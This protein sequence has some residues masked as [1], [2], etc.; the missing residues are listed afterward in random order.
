MAE[1]KK[2]AKSDGKSGL[3]G[4]RERYKKLQEKY[5]LPAF[6]DMNREFYIEK[7]AEIETDI[8]T[9]EIRRFVADKIYNYLR[10]LETILNP[11]NAPM[12]I[13]SVVKSMNEEDKRRL[14][15]AYMK[16]ADINLELV[17][18][19]VESDEKKDAEFFKSV[20][21]SWMEIKKDLSEI[22][23]RFT[24]GNGMRKQESNGSRY[25]G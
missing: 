6:D 4:F 17:R 12:F 14:S 20:Y 25:F 13:F 5:S 2:P 11:S 23:G 21:S 10:F 15:D 18:L 22:F 24:A 1:N 9:R 3:P 16:L 8:P 19:D 7:V